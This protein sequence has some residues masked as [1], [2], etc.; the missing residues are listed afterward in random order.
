MKSKKIYWE[1]HRARDDIL[2]EDVNWHLRY[3]YKNEYFKTKFLGCKKKFCKRYG[4]VLRF[5]GKYNRRIYY[6][7]EWIK[8]M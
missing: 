7:Y 4:T 5:L 3:F 6:S 2:Q 8:E 1:R